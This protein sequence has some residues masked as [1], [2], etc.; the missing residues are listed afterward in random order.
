MAKGESG[1]MS[2]QSDQVTIGERFAMFDA[3]GRLASNVREAWAPS[4]RRNC[5]SW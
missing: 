3:D 5:A 2:A 1:R 4:T